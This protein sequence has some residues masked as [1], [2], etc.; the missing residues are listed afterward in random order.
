MEGLTQ[1]ADAVAEALG[2]AAEAMRDRRRCYRKD[3]RIVLARRV[4]VLVILRR[5]P[6]ARLHEVAAAAGYRN[7]ASVDSARSDRE[8]VEVAERMAA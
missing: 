5:A 4:A 7:R 3:R 2:I 8:A 1:I 6:S